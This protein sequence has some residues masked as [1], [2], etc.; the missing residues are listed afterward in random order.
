MDNPRSV[1]EMGNRGNVPGIPMWTEP[2]GTQES[3]PGSDGGGGCEE[4]CVCVYIQL[5]T[6][7]RML[8]RCLALCVLREVG[9]FLVGDSGHGRDCQVK[10]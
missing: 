9:I 1:V 7:A 6:R 2:A 10:P 3:K 4:V 8:M 5:Y